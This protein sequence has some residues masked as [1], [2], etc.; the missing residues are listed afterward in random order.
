M[1]EKKKQ[2]DYYEKLLE[3]YGDHYLSLDWKSPESQGIRYRVFED[4]LTIGGKPDDFSLLD[5]GCGLGHFYEY[6]K[7]N[8]YRFKY[9]GYDISPKLIE[10]SKKK[11]P[12]V[13][14]QVRDILHDDH[15]EQSDFVFCCGALNISFEERE[16][17][18]DFIRSMLL[19]MF[20]LCKIGVG[21]NFLSSQAIYYLPDESLRQTQYFYSKPEEIVTLAKGMAE[22]FI[23]RHEYHPGDFTLY[24]LK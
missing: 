20:E 14:F 17:H 8:K 24:L 10:A 2:I 9:S 6:L 15:P 3:K 1:V 13:D 21:V 23:V 12:G 19:R 18:M 11:F 4:L 16:V 5:V 22:R 7:N